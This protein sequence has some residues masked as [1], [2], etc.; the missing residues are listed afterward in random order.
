MSDASAAPEATPQGLIQLG[1]VPP[2]GRYI[3]STW[4]RREFAASLAMGDLRSMHMDTVLGAF[5]HLLNPILLTAVYYVIFEL[6]LDVGSGR[7][8]DNYIAFLAVG[9]FS[10][11]YSQR[12]VM[13]GAGSITS[14][15]GLIRSLQFP[16]ALLPVAA[17]TRETVAYGY[18]LVVV[19]LVLVVTREPVTASWLVFLPILALQ[20]VFNIGA[21]LLA[22]RLSEQVRDI[23]NVL[24]FLFRLAF[25]FSG[26]IFDVEKLVPERHQDLLWI[27]TLNPFF[28]FTG[29][30]RQ[31][32]LSEPQSDL[33]PLM[34]ISALTWTAVILVVGLVFFRA[35]EHQY[36]RR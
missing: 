17:V 19:L 13:F 10:Y 16:R 27:F 6:V 26:T 7:G 31:Y 32:L 18:A 2:I 20:I 14:N 5:W 29:L 23:Q 30:P 34:W 33:L 35:G 21:A 25:Y 12:C 24:P 15:I 4:D 36:G 3:R 1:G 22:S 28:A 9:I 11:S 8:H